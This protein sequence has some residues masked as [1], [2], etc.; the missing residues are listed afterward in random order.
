VESR[1]ARLLAH[2]F[3]IHID[4]DSIGEVVDLLTK[5]TGWSLYR[6]S[7][8]LAVSETTLRRAALTDKGL[9]LTTLREIEEEWAPLLRRFYTDASPRQ[10]ARAILSSPELEDRLTRLLENS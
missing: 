4:R 6:L 1:H 9:T 3:T 7:G 10:A 8:E 2:L 5:R